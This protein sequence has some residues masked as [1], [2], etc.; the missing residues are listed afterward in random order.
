VKLRHAALTAGLVLILV[1][2][3]ALAFAQDTGPESQACEDATQAVADFELEARIG[4]ALEAAA[5]HDT[6]ATA[7]QTVA[8][9]ADAKATAEQAVADAA[10]ATVPPNI[11]IR[12]NAR[13]AAAAA[14]T[15]RDAA[16]ALVTQSLADRDAARAAANGGLQVELD[17]LIDARDA[18]CEPVVTPTPTPT[19]TPSATPTPTPTPTPGDD[20]YNCIDFPLSDGRTAQDVLDADPSDPHRLDYDKDRVACE[21]ADEEYSQVGTV[22]VGGVA[23][24]A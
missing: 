9:A 23:T 1:G 14:R 2:T 17:A 19:P 13:Q 24:G 21:L 5:R 11:S 18:A 8:V 6:E 4:V 3:P 15:A 20:D 22:P 7:Q 12:D 10:D 16:R